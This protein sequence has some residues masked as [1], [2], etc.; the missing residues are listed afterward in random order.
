MTEQSDLAAAL[1][2]KLEG[3]QTRSAAV[4]RRMAYSVLGELGVDVQKLAADCYT[5]KIIQ[6]ASQGAQEPLQAA[7]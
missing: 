7:E 5:R 3:A 4:L 1:V 2:S 6:S